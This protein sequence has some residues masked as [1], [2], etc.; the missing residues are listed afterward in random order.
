MRDEG[1]E[2][3]EGFV[4]LRSGDVMTHGQVM[5]FFE[6]LDKFSM[7]VMHEKGMKVEDFISPLRRRY[8]KAFGKKLHALFRE[9]AVAMNPDCVPE[10]DA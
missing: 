2:N 10:E 7:T 6:A 3:N 9:L 4:R 8:G 1:K 5:D